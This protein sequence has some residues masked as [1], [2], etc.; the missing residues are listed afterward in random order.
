M[1]AFRDLGSTLMPPLLQSRVARWMLDSL[2]NS[3][4][5]SYQQDLVRGANASAER[6][7]DDPPAG[8]LEG[9]GQH[10][11]VAEGTPKRCSQSAKR[12][13]GA[14]LA[15]QKISDR[16]PD[17]VVIVGGAVNM[18]R[19]DVAQHLP[20]NVWSTE[21]PCQILPSGFCSRISPCNL[22]R[23]HKSG[24]RRHLPLMVSQSRT[25]TKGQQARPSRAKRSR[26]PQPPDRSADTVSPP[27]ARRH[28][29]T[30]PPKPM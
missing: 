18:A 26:A 4:R 13:S 3:V 16:A 22:D 25:P 15:R 12:Y 8:R 27:R 21:A 28:R 2:D 10:C 6:P 19:H 11:D 29:E 30:P 20:G 1:S 17:Q 23:I 7:R 24:E 5:A 14:F 9:P